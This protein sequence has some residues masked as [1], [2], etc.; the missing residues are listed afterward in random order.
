[1]TILSKL[2]VALVSCGLLGLT[3]VSTIAAQGQNIFL[4]TLLEPN[5]KTP[6]VSTDELRQI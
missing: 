4:A 3:A 1:M 5:Q 2:L 6:E